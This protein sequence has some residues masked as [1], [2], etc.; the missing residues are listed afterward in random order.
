MAK[1]T[2]KKPTAEPA[3]SSERFEDRI[4]RLEELIDRIESGEVGLDESIDAYEQGIEIIEGCRSLLASAE[5]RVEELT[6]RLSGGDADGASE[7]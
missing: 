5:Q 6:E 7:P 2:S 4:A 1:K 3:D